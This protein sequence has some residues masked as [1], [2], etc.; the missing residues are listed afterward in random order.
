MFKMFKK[1]TAEIEQG[2]KMEKKAVLNGVFPILNEKDVYLFEMIIDD[3]PAN[4]DFLLFCQKDD[5]LPEDEWQ[6]PYNEQYLNQ[7]G[8]AVIGDAINDKNTDDEK[9]RVAFFMYIE[10]FDMPLST[11]YGDFQIK[12]ESEMPERLRRIIDYTPMD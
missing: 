5:N 11:P 10:S 1:K 3:V 7:E 8:T 2:E 9:T 4:V 6:V 12:A